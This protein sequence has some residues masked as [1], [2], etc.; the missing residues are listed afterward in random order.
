M[1]VTNIALRAALVLPIELRANCMF[2]LTEDE[3]AWAQ[4]L[5]TVVRTLIVVG[6][7]DRRDQLSR[8]VL[9][10]KSFAGNM[11]ALCRH[12]WRMMRA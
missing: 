7:L 5:S 11:W 8:G 2:R 4:E 10:G 1:F 6:M 9:P 12:R 3:A